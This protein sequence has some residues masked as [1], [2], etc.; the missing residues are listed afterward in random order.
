LAQGVVGS[1]GRL[2][3]LDFIVYE[4]IMTETVEDEVSAPGQQWKRIV[5]DIQSKLARQSCAAIVTAPIPRFDRSE[6][7]VDHLI[8]LSDEVP[9]EKL[10]I[11]LEALRAEVAACSN[12]AGSYPTLF[13]QDLNC[14]NV[15]CSAR[16]QPD[17]WTLDALIDFESAVVAD[18][19]LAYA[20][21][22]PWQDLRAFGHVV[23]GC[24]LAMRIAQC[25]APRCD[26][27]SLAE[28]HDKSRR[29]LAKKRGIQ[30]RAWREVL[31][32]CAAQAVAG[33]AV[34]GAA[35]SQA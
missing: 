24:W 9:L 12:A 25:R 17:A 33:V 26:A 27:M 21:G 8:S 20:E 23:K 31:A 35:G 34:A 5:T 4:F 18:A 19:R 10:R 15:L 2:Q 6:D 11:P 22:S 32:S 30:D 7:F 16:G 14:G 1:R 3:N 13:H 29:F 28:L